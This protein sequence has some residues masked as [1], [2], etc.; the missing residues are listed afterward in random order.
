MNHKIKYRLLFLLV[1]F[2]LLSIFTLETI[3]Y[4]IHH[5]Y[6][7]SSQ[8]VT[9]TNLT[10]ILNTVL[11]INKKATTHK[12]VTSSV[13]LNGKRTNEHFTLNLYRTHLHYLLNIKY[14]SVLSN[15]SGKIITSVDRVLSY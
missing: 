13:I 11:P 5:S 6:I 14:D 10:V 7:S 8:N 3:P 1:S 4:K 9:D 15:D 2:T 12:I